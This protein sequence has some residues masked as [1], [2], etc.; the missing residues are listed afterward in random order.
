MGQVAPANGWAYY[1][2]VTEE[3]DQYRGNTYEFI[4]T[5]GNRPEEYA[6]ATPAQCW[7][8]LGGLTL[9]FCACVGRVCSQPLGLFV[10]YTDIFDVQPPLPNYVTGLS[11]CPNTQVGKKGPLCQTA[12][13]TEARLTY[14]SVITRMAVAPIVCSAHQQPAGVPERALRL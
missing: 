11:P 12:E 14:A 13:T 6:L 4:A 5:F 1:A 8:G 9:E 7:R 2:W 10:K 3:A